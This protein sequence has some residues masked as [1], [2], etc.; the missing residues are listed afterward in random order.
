ML[1]CPALTSC[2]AESVLLF[3]QMLLVDSA[4]PCRKHV[5]PV[6]KQEA[7]VVGEELVKRKRFNRLCSSGQLIVE[8]TL[9]TLK[10]RF[11]YV[12]NEMRLKKLGNVAKIILVACTLHIFLIL[13]GSGYLTVLPQDEEEDDNLDE[14]EAGAPVQVDDAHA[15]LVLETIKE[16]V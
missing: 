4:Y 5:L 14:E 8:S 12:Y 1:S 3:A 16:E 13:T 11:P 6:Y 9:G 7:G 15:I 2:Y 10:S